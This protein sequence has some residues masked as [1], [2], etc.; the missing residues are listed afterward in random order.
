M[1]HFVLVLCI[2]RSYKWSYNAS[3]ELSKL[4]ST[5]LESSFTIMEYLKDWPLSH[6]PGIIFSQKTIIY[7]LRQNE[8]L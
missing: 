7:L 3:V 2:S 5:M 4:L 1:P 8:G 6:K